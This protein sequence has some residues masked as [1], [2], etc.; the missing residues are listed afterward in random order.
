[1]NAYTPTPV[2]ANTFPKALD[3]TDKFK[4]F[5]NKIIE[6]IPLFTAPMSY[7]PKTVILKLEELRQ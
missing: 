5:F 1:M 2:T 3:P 4:T 7:E 6:S